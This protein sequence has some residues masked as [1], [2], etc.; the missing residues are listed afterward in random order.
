MPVIEV[1]DYRPQFYRSL[2]RVCSCRPTQLHQTQVKL[3]AHCLLCLAGTRQLAASSCSAGQGVRGFACHAALY[4]RSKLPLC[5]GGT[6][7]SSPF[8]E[9]HLAGGRSLKARLVVGADG[10]RSQTRQL[11][12][13]RT[14][15]YSYGQ[16]G[17]VVSVRTA[18]PNRTAWQRFLPTGQYAQLMQARNIIWSLIRPLIRHAIGNLRGRHRLLC[19]GGCTCCVLLSG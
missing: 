12:Q 10:A 14:M 3:P 13:M 9:L 4:K 16:R 15:G 5:A 1:L 19:H 17:L 2:S 7:S 11:A 18:S 6:Q 8:A